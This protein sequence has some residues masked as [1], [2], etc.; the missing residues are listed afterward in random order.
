MPMKEH[1]AKEQNKRI[2]SVE[3]KTISCSKQE[4]RTSPRGLINAGAMRIFGRC[5]DLIKGDRIF[6]NR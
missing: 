4:I 1:F 6:A 3:F 5:G 2:H